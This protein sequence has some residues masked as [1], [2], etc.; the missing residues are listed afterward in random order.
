MP[1]VGSLQAIFS[2]PVTILSTNKYSVVRS[3]QGNLFYTPM[4]S[5]KYTP[6]NTV[7]EMII[8]WHLLGV[9]MMVLKKGGATQL[10]P[11][12][13]RKQGEDGTK[14]FQD[15]DLMDKENKD[16]LQFSL[17]ERL[18]NEMLLCNVLSQLSLSN[19][20]ITITCIHVL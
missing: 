1:F 11:T 2:S 12:Y 14:T 9:I 10:L 8:L 13:A 4:K 15:V 5:I 19:S 7:Q 16:V 17:R 18:P 20:G 3:Q 6:G